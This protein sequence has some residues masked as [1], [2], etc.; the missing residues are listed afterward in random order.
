MVFEIIPGTTIDQEVTY[1]TREQTKDKKFVQ[2]QP[3]R[4]GIYKYSIFSKF[5]DI[6]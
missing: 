1:P 4:M 5:G 2:L 3:F 6:D